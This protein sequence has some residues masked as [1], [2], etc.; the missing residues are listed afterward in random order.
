[1]ESQGSL[2]ILEEIIITGERKSTQRYNG[3]SRKNGPTSIRIAAAIIRWQWLPMLLAAPFFAL[4]SP[5]P[6][7]PLCVVPA[8]WLAIWLAGGQPLIRTP[9]NLP[10]LGIA[11]MILV[12]TWA[13]YDLKQSLEY[14][15]AAVFGLGVFFTVA[16]YCETAKGWWLCFFFYTGINLFL[17]VVVSLM[18]SCPQ[19]I[20]PLVPLTSHLTS[21]LIA[22]SKL[23]ETP[24]PN[25]IPVFLLGVLPLLIVLTASTLI[26]RKQWATI[27]DSKRISALTLILAVLTGVGSF[28]LL[29]SQSR[30]GYIS[31]AIACFFLLLVVLTPRNRWLLLAGVVGATIV[32]VA[33]WQRGVLS[34]IQA[35]LDS[36]ASMDTAF[37]IN[38]LQA[39]LEIWRRAIDGIRDFPITG[40]GMHTFGHAIPILYPLVTAGPETATLNA[41]NTY[42]QAALDLGLPGLIAFLG[43]QGGTLWML[44][45]I[46]RTVRKW[47]DI[48]QFSRSFFPP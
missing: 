26:Q 16:R 41:H 3:M 12:S 36:S 45:K 48:P 22:M 24:H 20:G 44:L 38:S 4:P 15:A 42:L 35:S 2:R 40:M 23:S 28:M 30:G 34:P 47:Q 18:V 5:W 25:T 1:M 32:I 27:I 7:I 13:S 33:L 46:W 8:M 37:S 14:I 31:F 17:A 29:L 21:P 39:R 9:L 43:V 11:M 10:I 6:L 19:K